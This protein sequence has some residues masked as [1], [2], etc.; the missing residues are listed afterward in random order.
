M[1]LKPISLKEYLKIRW[2]WLSLLALN[3]L[4]MAYV[5]VETRRLFIFDHAEIVWYRVMQLGQVHYHHLKC[6]PLI[7]GLLLAAIQYLPEMIGE[8]LRLSLHLPVSPHR[9]V[10]AHVLV[11][12][13]ALGLV[14]ALDLSALSL[15]TAR[16]FPAEAVATAL[17]TALPWCLAGMAA[18]LGATLALLE[19]GYRLKLF[20]LAVAAGVAGLFFRPAEPGGYLLQ[21]CNLAAFLLLLIPAVLLPAYRFRY[22]R[23]S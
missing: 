6:A 7:T 19:P 22:R 1:I 2:L 15:I 12:L 11:G 23:V 8:R 17:L 4:L 20:N 13:T 9:L 21:W 5:Y 14:I 16:F 18:Y 10:M 3:G